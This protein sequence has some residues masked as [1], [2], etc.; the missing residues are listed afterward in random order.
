[1]QS[2]ILNP[3]ELVWDEFDQKARAKQ[4]TSTTYLWQ[5]LQEI[6][7]E[8]SS[9]YLQSLVETKAKN[10]WSSDCSQSMSVWWMKSLRSFFA[11][12]FI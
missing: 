5:H 4:L 9:V 10:L 7:A 3:I 12:F 6:W 11:F 2:A 8:L 1:M